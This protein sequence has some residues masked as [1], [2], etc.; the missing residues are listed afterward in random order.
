[1]KSF[2]L[3]TL[4]L[5]LFS[6][7]MAAQT[8]GEDVEKL[9][10]I[11]SDVVVQYQL[12][13]YDEAL[14]LARSALVLASSIYGVEHMQTATSHINVGE[15]LRK[16][17]KYRESAEHLKI[18]Y[19]FFR[20]D[21]VTHE[22]TI[23]NI[24]E[25]L[26]TV[27]TLDKKQDEAEPFFTEAV[28]NAEQTFGKE[29]KETLPALKS[30]TVFYIYTKQY[31]EAENVF[32]RRF[33]IE[34]IYQRKKMADGIGDVSDDL[35]CYMSQ[36]FKGGEHAERSKAFHE[37]E[38]LQRVLRF[39]D[40]AKILNRPANTAKGGVI[41]G[42]AISLPRPPYP[43]SARSLGARG[44]VSVKVLIDERGN[45]TSAKGFCGDQIFFPVT[46][47]AARQA[48]FSPTLLSGVPVKVSGIITYNFVR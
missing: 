36:N 21:L 40:E 38:N 44:T 24:L 27:L 41:N 25:S 10:K 35:F 9:K 47:T 46:E 43:P 29:T 3:S 7:T 4:L 33:L 26:G 48:R 32:L 34:S 1:M 31:D 39:G 17:R 37:R 22:G 30:L 8:A 23:A 16:K 5:L 42:K 19:A 15:I 2:L 14:K 6:C 45:V 11:N 18:A 28:T 13:E 20:K 12:G